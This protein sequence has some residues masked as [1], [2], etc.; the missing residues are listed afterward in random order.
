MDGPKTAAMAGLLA[1]ELDPAGPAGPDGPLR[2]G[3]VTAVAADGTVSVIVA[4][5]AAA[6][7]GIFCFSSYAPVVNDIVWLFEDR[8]RYWVIG[9]VGLPKGP[10]GWLGQTTITAGQAGITAEAD[11]TGFSVTVTV[12]PSRRIRVSAALLVSRT[13]VD[14]SSTAYIKEGGTYLF[15]A[16]IEP[17]IANESIISTPHIPLTP[18]AGSHTYKLSL[19]RNSG[20]GTTALVAG[21]LFPSFILVEDI[22]PV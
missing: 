2:Q 8:G 19:L 10:L 3:K 20:T 21:A 11:L 5:A 15:Q 14:G 12:R 7:T 9:T 1:G 16:N 13:V 4:G 6:I 17:H 18:T 22:G